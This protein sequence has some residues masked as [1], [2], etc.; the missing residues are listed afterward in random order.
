MENLLL[1]LN[2]SHVKVNPTQFDY[3]LHLV[4]N[5]NTSHV[6][7]NLVIVKHQLIIL[8]NLNTSHV[9]VNQAPCHSW[10]CFLDMV[11]LDT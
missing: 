11:G 5:L 3:L 1:H 2:T 8:L 6:K 9:K 10:I 7:V 4:L